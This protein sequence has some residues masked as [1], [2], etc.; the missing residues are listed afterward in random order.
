MA[1]LIKDDIQSPNVTLSL[2]ICVWAPLG[3][4]LAMKTVLWANRWLLKVEEMTQVECDFDR[5]YLSICGF[6]YT[7][8]HVLP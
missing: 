3:L 4:V 6:M 5:G 7:H 2:R 8:A 1:L